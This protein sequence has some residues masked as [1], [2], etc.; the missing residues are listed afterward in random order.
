MHW[1]RDWRTSYVLHGW[2]SGTKDGFKE[3]FG[4]FGG[5]N[6]EYVLSRESNFARA[7]YEVVKYALDMGVISK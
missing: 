7:V 4:K 1:R 6:L 5:I 3:N 2:N